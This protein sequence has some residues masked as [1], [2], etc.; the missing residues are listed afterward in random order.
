LKTIKAE[1]ESKIQL[2]EE[3]KSTQEREIALKNKLV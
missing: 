3:K 1:N 2:L